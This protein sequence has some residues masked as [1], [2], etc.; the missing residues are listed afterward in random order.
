MN[1]RI[2]GPTP[3]PPE[4]LAAVGKQM[5]DHRGPEF[6]AVL[7]DVSSGL[8]RAFRTE[9]DVL[10]FTC[11]GTGALEAAVVNTLSPGQRVLA[12]SIG[13]FGNRF[14]SIARTYGADVASLAAEP[15]HAIEPGE[16]DDALAKDP[17]VAAVLLTHNETST[18]VTNPLRDL[19]EVVRRHDKLL[20]VDAISSM[21]SVPIEVDAWGLDVVLSGSQKGWMVPPGLAFM[22][23]SPRAWAANKTAKMP[24]FYLDAARAKDSAERGQTP[25]TPAVSLYYGMQVALELLER[26]GWQNVYA[27]HQR[28][29]D[30]ART[31]VRSLGLELFADPRYASNTVTCVKAPEGVDVSALRKALREKH[32]TVLAGGQGAL[33]GKV[34]RIG[35]LG[36]VNEQD[37][38]AVIVALQHELPQ[39]GFAPVGASRA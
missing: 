16:L 8:K 4:V 20:L 6:A 19:A 32:Q 18:G 23:M 22:S 2:P 26:E 30:I 10:I 34:F 37:V 14:A 3:C 11:A 13:E 15:G 38:E 1:L 7:K 36:L 33:T 12:V 39:L 31:G 35:H 17:A 28:C 29:A 27:R 9:N 24:R 21:G 5:V 25:W